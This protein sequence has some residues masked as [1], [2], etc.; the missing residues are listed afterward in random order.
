MRKTA[1][2]SGAVEHWET[3]VLRIMLIR[4]GIQPTL[5]INVSSHFADWHACLLC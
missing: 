3:E 5:N 1:P 2:T 4:A